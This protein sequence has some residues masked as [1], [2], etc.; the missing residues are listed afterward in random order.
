[1][2]TYFYVVDLVLSQHHDFSMAMNGETFENLKIG[3]KKRTLGKVF[4][5]NFRE[6]RSPKQ[7]DI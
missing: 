2:V 3:Y 6:S 7:L 5:G 4:L 1:M